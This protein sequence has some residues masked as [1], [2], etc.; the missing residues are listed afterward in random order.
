MKKIAIDRHERSAEYVRAAERLGVEYYL[1]DC[2]ADDIINQLEDAKSLI[3]HWHHGDYAQKRVAKSIIYAAEKKGICVYP[4]IDTCETFDDKV[5]QKYLLEANGLPL[6]ETHVFLDR[7][8]AENFLKCC[9]YPIVTKLAGGAG[10]TNVKMVKSEKEGLRVCSERFDSYYRM[11]M[12]WGKEK[13]PKKALWYFKNEDNRRYMGE[14]KG[15]VLFQSFLPNNTYD[16][17]VTIIGEEKAV[18]FK[19]YVRDN[20]FRASGSGKIDYEIGEKD[21]EAIKIG[22]EAA[23]KLKAQTVAFDF[24][25]DSD[26]SLKIIEM[27]YGFVSKAVFDAKGYYTEDGKWHGNPVSVEEEIVLML[28][29]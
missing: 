29:K 27:S 3:W 11:S 8:K 9:E 15:Y 28:S 6:V 23:H 16:I 10:S 2:L 18:I 7:T 4:N 1:V 5:A 24:A 20:D 26:M 19:R 21:K 25:Y 22:F 14:D 12:N 17:R 13:N